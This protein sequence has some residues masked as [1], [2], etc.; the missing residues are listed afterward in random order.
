MKDW[1]DSPR[2]TDGQ[3]EAIESFVK[4]VPTTMGLQDIV[5]GMLTELAKGPY[6][7]I[8]LYEG[9]AIGRTNNEDFV[10]HIQENT[11]MEV[12]DLEGK[13]LEKEVIAEDVG[14]EDEEEEEDEEED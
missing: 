5:D 10:E 11:D 8:V 14:Y 6:R 2:L 1:R 13:D 12:W 4:Q 9:S 3:K 7:Y